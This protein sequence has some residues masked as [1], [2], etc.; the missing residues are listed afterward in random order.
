MQNLADRLPNA[1]LE[2]FEGGHLFMV[3]DKRAYES[4]IAFL[5]ETNQ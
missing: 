1:T 5:K 4:L 2:F 3:Q